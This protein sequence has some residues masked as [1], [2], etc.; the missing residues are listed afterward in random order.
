MNTRILNRAGKLP[1]DG[2]YQFEAQGEHV[3]HAAKVIQVIDEKA[4]TSIANRF[5]AEAAAQG[6]D[7]PGIRIDKDHLS[8]SHANPTESLGWAMGIRN[9]NGVPE[10]KIDWTGLGLPLV[11]ATPGKPP[12]YKFFS[13]E[14]EPIECEVI[15]TRLINRKTYSVVRPLR[16]VGLSL[17]NDPN[18]KGQKPISNRNGDADAGNHQP[19]PNMKN[20]MTLL[21]LAE[22]APEASAVAEIQ[23]IK[24]RATSAETEVGTLKTE[25]DAL[26]TSQV[27]SDLERLKNRFKPDNRDK[28]KAALI[29]NR[30]GTLELLEAMEPAAAADG[31]NGPIT[32]R[33]SATPPAHLPGQEQAAADEVRAAKI[34]NRA[35]ALRS[36]DPSLSLSKAYERAEAELSAQ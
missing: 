35:A 9:R 12:V 8:Q 11:E 26:L 5:A 25:R 16:L 18:N 6:D 19:D 36:A 20:I 15:G 32:N 1:D 33:R 30:N 28:I 10:A 2:W 3:N 34:S 14:Y 22:D 17:T 24:N 23:K 29:S 31:G 13:T 4:V 21:G 7:F 27:E